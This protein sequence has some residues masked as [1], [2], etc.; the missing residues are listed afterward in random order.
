[1]KYGKS[2]WS[3]KADSEFKILDFKTS[4]ISQGLD[5]LIVS[6]LINEKYVEIILILLYVDPKKLQYT[7]K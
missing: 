4:K 5:F 1:M 2:I 6:V 7:L 3:F